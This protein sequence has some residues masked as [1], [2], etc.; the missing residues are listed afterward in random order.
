MRSCGR[1]LAL[2]LLLVTPVN[3]T[4]LWLSAPTATNME[5]GLAQV[6][7]YGGISDFSN[8]YNDADH[9]GL[10]NG[11]FAYGGMTPDG[12]SWHLDVKGQLVSPFPQAG[13]PGFV[14]QF[15]SKVGVIGPV[16]G[17]SAFW[18]HVSWNSMG[19]P[20]PDYAGAGLTVS[21]MGPYKQHF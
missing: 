4:E 20:P 11:D 6:G 21:K 8:D 7:Q 2:T 17:T 15:N 3:A 14:T 9:G 13:Q 19:T 12:G 10:L 16:Y 18:V 5:A 1:V